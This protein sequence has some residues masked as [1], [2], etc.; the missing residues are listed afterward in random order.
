MT[1]PLQLGWY[2]RLV[3]RE[4]CL[5]G[6]VKEILQF[7]SI[8]LIQFSQDCKGSDA[9][10]IT[11]N[12]FSKVLVL[13]TFHTSITQ[14]GLQNIYTSAGKGCRE[15]SAHNVVILVPS[16]IKKC[17]CGFG[18]LTL[19]EHTQRFIEWN[20]MYCKGVKWPPWNQREKE[21]QP[22]SWVMWIKRW[23]NL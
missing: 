21:M 15:C 3:G 13:L 14:K 22:C 7:F 6:R 2:N 23:G 10:I 18:L 20:H 8:D 11:S 17:V 19:W 5:K 4:Q 9:L 1:R 16:L 12:A